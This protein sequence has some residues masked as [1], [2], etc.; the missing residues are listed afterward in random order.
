ML[1]N[2]R[3]VLLSSDKGILNC[4]RSGLAVFLFVVVVVVVF[5]FVCFFFFFFVL[6]SVCLF[7]FLFF[8]SVFSILF[9]S[10]RARP[11]LVKN[12]ILLASLVNKWKLYIVRKGFSSQTVSQFR[13][14]PILICVIY[15]EV[16]KKKKKK[17][18]TMTSFLFCFLSKQFI[19]NKFPFD[20]VKFI[21]FGHI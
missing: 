2:C 15:T 19:L 8:F 5:S 1:C 10:T 9:S 16:V 14:D 4:N 11:V 20:T 6:F 13:P 3:I 7:F 17:K 21:H 18:R 12:M